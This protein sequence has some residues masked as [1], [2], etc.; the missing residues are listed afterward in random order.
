LEDAELTFAFPTEGGAWLRGLGFEMEELTGTRVTG[1]IDVGP[2]HHTPFG[3]AHGGMFATIVES[4]GS[5]GAC[6]AVVERGER[7]VGVHNSTDFLRPVVEGRIDV[8][9]KPIQQGRVQQLWEVEFRR[10]DGKVVALGRLRLQNLPMSP[11][12]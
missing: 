8:E 10:S 5:L 9:A 3:V 2:E 1:H 11:R 12:V 4:V 6:A 7:A